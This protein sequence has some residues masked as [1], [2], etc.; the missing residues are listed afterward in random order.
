MQRLKTGNVDPVFCQQL[1][2]R[3]ENYVACYS[4]QRFT[5]RTASWSLASFR[6][7]PDVPGKDSNRPFGA[8]PT[9]NTKVLYASF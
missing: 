4:I 1:G 8:S 7:T 9:V 2:H 5:L 3:F 6:F